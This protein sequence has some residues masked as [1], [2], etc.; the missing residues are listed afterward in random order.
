MMGFLKETKV[1]SGPDADA[2]FGEKDA[3]QST[4]PSLTAQSAIDER[5]LMAKID[6]HV[7]PALCVMYLFAFLD[8]W[9]PT[10]LCALI[11]VC[12]EWY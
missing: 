3:E 2:Q 7:V 11:T 8:R 10:S 4:S 6:W 5:K 9:V 1:D 12:T